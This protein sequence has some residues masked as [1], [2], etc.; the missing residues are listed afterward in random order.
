MPSICAC[1]PSPDL[2]HAQVVARQP[3]AEAHRMRQVTRVL[4]QRHRAAADVEGLAVFTLQLDVAH[5]RIRRDRNLGDGIGQTG[6]L[7]HSHVVLDDGDFAPGVRDDQA[8]RISRSALAGG[9]E[10]QVNRR[11]QHGV[12]CRM[13]EHAVLQE[14]GV[15]RRKQVIVVFYQLRQMR[16]DQRAVFFQRVGQQLHVMPAGR[17]LP[18]CDS[19]GT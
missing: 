16:L 17:V 9:H 6:F 3:R 18:A 2:G 19:A 10:Q 13:D 7:A 1:A 12:F 15:Q 4:R 5:R 8:A 11:L 14:G